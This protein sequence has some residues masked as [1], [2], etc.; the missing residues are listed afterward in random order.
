MK[1]KKLEIVRKELDK[2]DQKLLDLFKIRTELVK[3][4][5][6][7]KKFKKQIVDRQRIKKVLL[8][9]KKSSIKRRI[10]PNI[11]VKIWKSIINSY[12]NFERK[13][14]SKK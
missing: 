3:K 11:T 6:K 7:L 9:I 12:I 1:K 8:R 14:F 10:D 4:V 13:N 2:L 5:I